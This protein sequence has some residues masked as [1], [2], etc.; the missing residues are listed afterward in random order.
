MS[1]VEINEWLKG[2]GKPVAEGS[3]VKGKILEKRLRDVL[4]DVGYKSE[5][6]VP[7]SQF[8]NPDEV[9][10]GDEI[11]VLVE[12]LENEDGMIVVSREKASQKQNWEKIVKLYNEGI[13]IEGKVKSVVKGGL[14]LDIGVEAFLPAS[15]IDIV[16]PKN[17]KDFEGK[18]LV[19]KVVKLNEDRKNVVLSRR[20]LVEAE[21][22]EKRAKFLAEVEKGSLVHGVVKNITEFGAFIDLDGIDGLLHI[23]DMSWT[24]INH[25]S[26]ILSVGQE[27]E[28]VVTEIDKEKERVS[29]GLKQ[30][31]ENPWDKIADKYPVNSKVHGKVSSLTAYGAFVELEPGIEGLIHISELSWTKRVNK[32]ADILTLGQ[33][34]DALVLDVN[35]EEQKISLSLRQL[36]P[37][38]WD[39]VSLKYPQGTIV[40]G[41]VRSFTAYGAFVELP[42]GLDGMIHVSD[43]SWTRK[44]NHPS[45]MLKKGQEVEAVV[46][47]IDKTN[48]RISLGIKQLTEDPW[49]N[50]E[51]IY[52]V[53]DIVKGKVSKIA[54]FGAFVQLA[55]EIDGLVH[56]SQISTERV[57]RVKD[58][59]KVG[60]EVEA[61][62][63]KVDKTERRIGLSIKAVNFSEE[64]FNAEKER[65]E[66]IKPGEELSS[67]GE[68]FDRA[69]E[70][71]RPGEGKK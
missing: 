24:R 2:I 64:Q 28:L 67:F 21:R 12:N 5:G 61:R 46:L 31:T 30:K 55:D 58:V 56:I 17:L 68:A 66:A 9:K 1:S 16:V 18:T 50:I 45:E 11:E 42:D 3:I 10:V 8:D 22:A 7:L 62:I 54:S 63:V 59:L 41:V 60:Q 44:I 65:Y 14:M 47:E 43:L 40:K 25:P 70:E 39:E 49:K 38:P 71:Y 69:Q 26:E 23:T 48:Q 19:C 34:I 53:G 27:I 52:K 51:K 6:V 57:N 15:Q 36:E 33:E 32:P 13:P 29:L 35:K 4:V 37:N 20:E